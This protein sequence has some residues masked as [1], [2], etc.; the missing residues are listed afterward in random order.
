[1][2]QKSAGRIGSR[3]RF[4]REDPVGSG[5]YVQVSEVRSIG[6]P[7]F[8]REAVDFTHLDSPDDYEEFKAGLKNGGEISLVL[9]FRPDHVTQGGVSGLQKD[10]E[11]GTE[12]NWR[13]EW[14]Q[15]ANTPSLTVPGF[16]TGWELTTSA[17]DA[18]TAAVKIKVTGKSTLAN[19]A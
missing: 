5:T 16:L 14:P 13:I 12:R 4:L 11:D 19:F 2:P 18:I 10:F 6:G 8:S 15:F 9:T 1:M 17:K 7:S 3:A